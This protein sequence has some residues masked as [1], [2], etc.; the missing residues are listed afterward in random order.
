MGIVGGGGLGG[1]AFAS[2]PLITLP[3]QEV[4]KQALRKM[5]SSSV[6][7]EYSSRE[8]TIGE[9]NRLTLVFKTTTRRY[10]L[11]QQFP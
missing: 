2:V 11:L 7:W 10:R 4:K 9:F 8:G 3:P 5:I 1:S 6:L